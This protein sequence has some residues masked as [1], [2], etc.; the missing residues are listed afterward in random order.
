MNLHQLFDGER[1]GKKRFDSPLFDG[2]FYKCKTK[3]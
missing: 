2:L 1:K 3:I